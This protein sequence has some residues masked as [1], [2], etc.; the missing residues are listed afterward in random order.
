METGPVSIRMN[1]GRS[2]EVPS[3]EPVRIGQM[4]AIMLHKGEEGKWRN[5]TLPLV[6]LNPNTPLAAESQCWKA[7]RRYARL[8]FLSHRYD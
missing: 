1:D 2:Y 4:S 8:W 7:S 6:T 5:I 3:R